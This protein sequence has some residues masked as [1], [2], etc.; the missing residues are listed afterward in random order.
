MKTKQA[1]TLVEVLIYVAL[2]GGVLL[3]GVKFLWDFVRLQVK[4]EARQEVVSSQVFGLNR[5]ANL[6]HQARKI[7]AVSSDQLNLN[8]NGSLKS[9]RFN[10][11][12]LEEEIGGQWYALDLA[13][14]DEVGEFS[15]QNTDNGRAKVVGLRLSTTRG[16][17]AVDWRIGVSLTGQ[18]NMGRQLLADVSRAYLEG[19]DKQ[20]LREIYWHNVGYERVSLAGL[21]A[22]WVGSNRLRR[23][24]LGGSTVWSGSANS[25]ELVEWTDRNLDV[26]QELRMDLDF[27]QSLDGV[28][29]KLELLLADKSLALA[30][31]VPTAGGGGGTITCDSYCQGLGYGGGVCRNHWRSCLWND[32]AYESGGD[33]YCTGG[34]SADTCCCTREPVR[35]CDEICQD[36]GY[37]GGICRSSSW[38]CR[39]NDETHESSGD[40]W[41]TGGASAD[42]CCC[43]KE[44]IR[45]C[46]DICHDLGYDEGT[47]RRNSWAC[48]SNDETHEDDG[49]KW[50]T[51]G[52]SADTCCCGG[53]TPIKT[54]DSICRDLGYD[55]GTCRINA[56]DCRRNGETHESDG[57]PYCLG[58]PSADTCCCKNSWGW[59]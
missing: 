35:T 9:L 16:D 29:L 24:A 39:S 21:R 15:D 42:T 6:V 52:P 4:D 31:L 41:C 13:G 58:G 22:S 34:P 5:F 43:S 2:S 18:F 38:A 7:E 48:R 46:A 10:N 19:A 33:Q 26:D 8:I 28:E 53:G 37:N 11:G 30:K 36:L 59:W 32:E 54:C 1:Y 3:A 14:N 23:V 17:E 20:L 25:G 45:T 40:Q 49:D 47:C 55:E 44:P 27:D 50:C 57:D 51:G 56:R 12:H